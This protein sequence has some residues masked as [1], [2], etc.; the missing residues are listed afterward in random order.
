MSFMPCG[1]E[2]R[3]AGCHALITPHTAEV[4]AFLRK[5][6]DAVAI[7]THSDRHCACQTDS[8]HLVSV[9]SFDDMLGPLIFFCSTSVL[10]FF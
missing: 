10:L 1:G 3:G 9:I 4:F 8:D 2:G 6:P 5:E 7:S